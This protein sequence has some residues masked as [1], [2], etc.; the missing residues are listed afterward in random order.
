MI[1][2]TEQGVV[3]PEVVMLESLLDDLAAGRL[4]V[5]RFQ[6]PFVWEPEQM[7]DLFDSIERGY[8]IGSLLV[9]ETAT[10][11]PSLDV[12]AGIDVPAAPADETVSY[13]L[14]GHQRLST[15][16]GTLVKRPPAISDE[17]DRKWQ[18]YRRL[19]EPASARGVRFQHGDDVQ[20][21][22]VGLLPLQAVLRTM[23][24]L[25]YARRLARDPALADQAEALVDEAERLAQQIKGYRIAVIR[26]VGGGLSHAVEAFARL[27]SG[28]RQVSPLDIVSALTYRPGIVRSLTDDVAEIQKST[29]DSRFG[30]LSAEVV[31]QTIVAI[32]GA[33]ELV[34][35]R[36]SDF[37][38]DI[39]SRVDGLVPR[40]AIALGRAVQFLRYEAG[41]PLATLVPYPLQVVLLA[42]F[43]DHEPYPD[44]ALI[45]SLVRWFW[46]ASWSGTLRSTGTVDFQASFDA[47]RDYP[48]EIEN[49]LPGFGRPSPLPQD[50]DEDHGRLRAFV[51]WEMREF[52][53]RLDL[54]GEVVDAVDLYAKSGL[55]AY[56]RVMS[57]GPEAPENFV[58]LP[59]VADI[60]ESLPT[61][62]PK[63]LRELVISHGIPAG[64]LIHLLSGDAEAFCQTRRAF[65]IE[66]EGDFMQEMGIEPPADPAAADHEA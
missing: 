18:I 24:F 2:R 29:A 62:P 38:A 64:A 53:Q 16:F 46:A 65:L 20:D 61:L 7:L 25:A 32:S 39:R 66:R 63:R 31:F 48:A 15:L 27:N 41:I 23:D 4:R 59:D 54:A 9:W 47:M 50:F 28:G 36:W 8:P 22:E 3:K 52:G 5:P 57:G 12:V 11:V 10:D 55:H 26:L 6:R 42:V 51:A 40:A 35:I 43:Y 17:A 14:D 19:G 1:D 33:D 60:E 45:R 49:L 13:L 21:P 30:A 58:M 44:R 56:R 37:A 34:S